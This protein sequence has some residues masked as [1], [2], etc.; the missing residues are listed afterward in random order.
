MTYKNLT[1]QYRSNP[2]TKLVTV[3]RSHAYIGSFN[4]DPRA[5]DFNTE[6]GILIDSPGLAEQLSQMIE[7]L[8]QPENS[9]RVQWDQ[10]GKLIWL[11]GDK[12]LTRQPARSFWQRV[13]A[14]TPAG[15]APILTLP[16]V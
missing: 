7:K 12:I 16:T 10:N 6:M 11:S 4:L 14:P 13:Q 15:A 1:L 3:D 8:M 5:G 9:W 2:T